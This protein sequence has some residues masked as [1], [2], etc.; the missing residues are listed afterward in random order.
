MDQEISHQPPI[1][2]NFQEENSDSYLGLCDIDDAFFHPELIAR[3]GPQSR[4]SPKINISPEIHGWF[5]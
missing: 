4:T 3:N 2:K 5:R 1:S